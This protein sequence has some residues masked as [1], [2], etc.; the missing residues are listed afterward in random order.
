M[1]FG[2]ARCPE[3]A[4]SRALGVQPGEGAVACVEDNRES[5][6]AHPY[7]LDHLSLWGHARQRALSESLP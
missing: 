2:K 3:I 6:L 1:N 5:N 7:P 4:T